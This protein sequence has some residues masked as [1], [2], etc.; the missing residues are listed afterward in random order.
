MAQKRSHQASRYCEECGQP[1]ESRQADAYLCPRCFRL[2]KQEKAL[3]RKHKQARRQAR[4]FEI[5]FGEQ[6]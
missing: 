1:F 2:Q 3:A 6:R 4:F 5:E